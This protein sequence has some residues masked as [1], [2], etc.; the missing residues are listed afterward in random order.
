MPGGRARGCGERCR[1]NGERTSYTRRKAKALLTEKENETRMEIDEAERK[2]DSFH[3]QVCQMKL[4]DKWRVGRSLGPGG[5]HCL[6]SLS[7][8]S[9]RPARQMAAA[10]PHGGPPATDCSERS[11]SAWPPPGPP[12]PAWACPLPGPSP[13]PAS[14]LSQHPLVQPRLESAR[15]EPLSEAPCDLCLRPLLCSQGGSRGQ[16]PGR[17]KTGFAAWPG[18]TW[19]CVLLLL[20]TSGPSPVNWGLGYRVLLKLGSLDRHHRHHLESC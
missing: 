18:L 7:A 11:L 17:D 19:G 13:S 2:G 16:S 5:A 4:R 6:P 14:P 10:E 20:Q 3:Q 8:V 9:D 1:A 12:C 15:R